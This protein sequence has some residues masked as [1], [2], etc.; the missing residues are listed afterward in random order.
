MTGTPLGRCMLCDQ[1]FT[2]Q[3]PWDGSKMSGETSRSLPG[4][5]NP[6]ISE[7]KIKEGDR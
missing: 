7:K 2:E 3:L 4:K 6:V 1:G 5:E